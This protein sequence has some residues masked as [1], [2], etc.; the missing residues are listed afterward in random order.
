MKMKNEITDKQRE[1]LAYI[2]NLTGI[3]EEEIPE[4][5][6]RLLKKHFSDEQILNMLRAHLMVDNIS[7][8]LK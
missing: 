7:N 3:P 6:F 4:F 8:I 2:H 1:E 5:C